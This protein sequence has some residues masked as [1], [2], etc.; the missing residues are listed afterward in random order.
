MI[1][2]SAVSYNKQ[3]ALEPRSAVFGTDGA[4]LGR[5]EENFFV[6]PDAK[7][8]V[9]RVQASIRSSGQDHRITSLS[10][11][12]PIVLNGL[13][14]E[15]KREYILQPGDEI[16]VGPYLLFAEAHL[17][18]VSELPILA[19][20][21]TVP[22]TETVPNAASAPDATASYQIDAPACADHR[23]LLDAFL[24]GAGISELTVANGLTPEFM[25]TIGTLLGA[26]IEGTFSLMASR[27][28]S[29]REV[30]ADTTIV[31]V[32]NN[33]PLKFLP[34]S[35]SV[36]MQ[37]LRKKMPGFMA[38][39][40]AIEDAFA[41]LEAHQKG[42]TAGMHG[43]VDMLLKRLDPE[44]IERAAPAPAMLEKLL[45]PKRM[46]DIL[47]AAKANHA[48]TARDVRNDFQGNFGAAFLSAYDAEI[49]RIKD[50]HDA[51]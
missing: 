9:S 23:A 4:T 51:D 33:N 14:L 39:V 38:P 8:L 15:F 25:E 29:K 13:E 5:S 32:R 26:T 34:D 42:T 6:L 1:K 19:T 40:E 44:P 35:R 22:I 7:H 31:V 41:D 28:L 27:A 50:A 3:R 36:L 11:A 10:Q 47:Q 37:M 49:E 24:R 17:A 20:L 18:P 46:I 2:I 21:A 30:N 12:N 48:K 43:V 45:P 16:Q